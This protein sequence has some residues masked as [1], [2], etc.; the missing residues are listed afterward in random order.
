[1]KIFTRLPSSLMFVIRTFEQTVLTYF[2]HWYLKDDCRRD[3]LKRYSINGVW[4]IL[5]CFQFSSLL[6]FFLKV[7]FSLLSFTL[8]RLLQ[9]DFAFKL[10]KLTQT[11]LAFLFQTSKRFN[12]FQQNSI[13]W[14]ENTWNNV[15][16]K[17][18]PAP[19]LVPA[20]LDFPNL[21]VGSM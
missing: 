3:V 16:N 14:K 13:K 18:F 2:Q 1:M 6:D 5:A 4:S 9:I 12:E 21:S 15:N 11:L 17:F 20:F 8:F 10:V 7:F 19:L